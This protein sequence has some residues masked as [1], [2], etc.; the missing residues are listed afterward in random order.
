MRKACSLV[1]LAMV[2]V[3]A[4][5]Y[6]GTAVYT[7]S[8]DVVQ[9]PPTWGDSAT[10]VYTANDITFAGAS[11]DLQG[12]LLP[13][14]NVGGT[15]TDVPP[16]D[17][18][19]SMVI[20]AAEPS[21]GIGIAIANA[22]DP[23]QFLV[24]SLNMTLSVV[25]V[26]FLG[27]NELGSTEIG[28]LPLTL[29][30]TRTGDTV[31]LEKMAADDAGWVSVA[32]AD[33]AALGAADWYLSF[34]VAKYYMWDTT[35]FTVDEIYLTGPHIP[36]VNEYPVVYVDKG[37]DSGIE[38]GATWATAFTTIQEGI[39]AAYADGGGEVWVAEGVYD[40]ARDNDTG[41]VVM[42]EYVH[43]YGGFAG[44]ETERDQRDWDAH[45]TVI[46]GSTSRG[47]EPAYHVVVGA[48]AATLD[49]F[50]VTG[51]HAQW[52]SDS[53]DDDGGGMYNSGSSPTVANCTFEGN[54]AYDRGGG[55]ANC[56]SS[57]PTVTNCVFRNN[58]AYSYAGGGMYNGESCSP[59]VTNCVFEANSAQDRGGGMGNWSDSCSPT[60]SNCTFQDNSAGFVGG[61]MSNMRCSTMVTNCTFEANSAGEE[62]GGMY[63]ES[64]AV[65][66][67]NCTFSGNTASLAGGGIY[68]GHN[69]FSQA[70]I[71]VG[72]AFVGN[73][74]DGEG[75]AIYSGMGDRAE[76]SDSIFVDNTATNGGGIYAF[77]ARYMSELYDFVTDCT[78]SGNTAIG[79]GGAMYLNNTF[80]AIPENMN[81]APAECT[82]SENHADRGGAIYMGIEFGCGPNV[83]SC[84]FYNNSARVG[85]ALFNEGYELYEGEAWDW[86]MMTNCVLA[87]NTAQDAGGGMYNVWISPRLLHCTL[88]SNTATSSGGAMFND[89]AASPILLNCILWN[90]LP[91]EIANLDGTSNPDVT[92]SDIQGGYPGEGNISVDPLFV[93]AANGDFHLLQ[94]SPC[95]DA[96]RYIDYFTSDFEGD[97]RGYDGTAEPRG[98]GSDYDMGADEYVPD[99]DGDGLADWRETDTGVYIDPTD[100]GTDPNDPDTDD[101]GLSDGE[102]VK[103][104]LTNPLDAD[105]DDDGHLD[106]VEVAR[107]TD[108]LDPESFPRARGGSGEPCFIATAAYGTASAPEVDLLREFRD[109]Y[110]LTN[111]VGAAF[112]RAYYRLS[113]PVARFIATHDLARAGVRTCLAPVAALVRLMTNSQVMPAALILVAVATVGVLILVS[114]GKGRDALPRVRRMSRTVGTC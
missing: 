104:Y 47:G 29:R 107:G 100:T 38:D 9:F 112:V 95:V 94:A 50:T 13:I 42:E 69:V 21:G 90:D 106:G 40:E 44:T 86:L 51:G 19:F 64:S 11:G 14:D 80:S 1:V 73:S 81:A 76:I 54:L 84:R 102:E 101:D 63:N 83:A 89:E 16:S 43:L 65:I 62:G 85:G 7:G 88:S 72:C 10:T 48:N 55:M 97:P 78:F 18:D 67:T 3:C 49:G 82:F 68:G 59:V 5:A 31:V 25:R 75:G 77:T 22:S 37:N 109:G 71:V 39:D 105:T 114:T 91:D 46:D 96:G 60:I 66:V 41:S 36:N 70:P 103:I 34:A 8:G 57:S 24:L 99:T 2:S 53:A 32:T 27:T 111:C 98:D 113:P 74:T 26:I 28:A 23:Y 87:G 12:V 52:T 6:A 45:V 20:T 61:G 35:S 92:F 79:D 30:M 110:L 108:P 15:I 58:A 33:L 4:T 56:Y 17:F 93:D